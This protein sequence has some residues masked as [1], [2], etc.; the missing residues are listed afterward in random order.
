VL[1]TGVA[2]HRVA[3]APFQLHLEGANPY[4]HL[5][6]DAVRELY[7][8]PIEFVEARM[9]PLWV[10]RNF[11]SL[12][13]VH[14]HWPEYLLRPQVRSRL[15]N[16]L[17][18]HVAVLSVVASVVLLRLTRTPVVWTVHNVRPHAPQTP[19][20]QIGLYF[21]LARLAS[22]LLVHTEHARQAVRTR[23]RAQTPILVAPHGH[24]IDVISG[25]ECDRDA[26]RE[27][28]GIA[29][30]AFVLIAFGQI[31]SYK[32]VGALVREF[33]A[34]GR[35]DLVLIVAGKGVEPDEVADLRQ[36]AGEDP[37]VILDVRHI[38]DDDMVRLHTAADAVVLYYNEMFSSGALLMGLSFSLP[39]LSSSGGS[40]GEI[41]DPPAVTEFHL[42]ELAQAVAELERYGGAAARGAAHEAALR[43]DWS[44]AATA[45][46]EAY[47]LRRTRPA[48]GRR[49]PTS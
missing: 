12:D 19:A 10:I 35:D 22:G 33:R 20:V 39:V 45:H 43:A 7:D 41:G 17:L 2:A 34:I 36:A 8:E 48:A 30:D 37:H 31:R 14:L 1:T 9:T 29:T 18:A 42:G 25:Q 46:L 11:R 47:G 32:Q 3:V 4:Q 16:W 23:F 21:A 5:L 27:E 24:Y 40:A 38:P 15:A 13:A 6:Y 49:P 44:A 28:L 26:V